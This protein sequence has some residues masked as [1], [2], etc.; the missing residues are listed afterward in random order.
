MTATKR[1]ELGAGWADIYTVRTHGMVRDMEAAVRKY[2]DASDEPST[3]GLRTKWILTLTKQWSGV[4]S[5][6]TGELLDL[7]EAGL[8]AADQGLVERLFEAVAEAYADAR[9]AEQLPQA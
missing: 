5:P 4:V 2:G 1:V 7:N 9:K 6:L 3:E 8:D